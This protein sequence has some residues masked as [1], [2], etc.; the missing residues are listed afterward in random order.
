MLT[1]G[2]LLCV[3]HVGAEML[4]GQFD[5]LSAGGDQFRGCYELDALKAPFCISS[6]VAQAAFSA[7]AIAIDRAIVREYA[8]L[9]STASIFGSTEQKCLHH[10]RRARCA[11]AFRLSAVAKVCASTCTELVDAGCNLE[12]FGIEA[13]TAGGA[14]SDSGA[15]CADLAT[16]QLQCAFGDPVSHNVPAVPAARQSNPSAPRPVD[17]RSPSVFKP[18]ASSSAKMSVSFAYVAVALLAFV[19]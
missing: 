17:P 7:T 3:V 15:G 5:V 2:V 18:R 4:C 11:E 10:W 16:S 1:L 6:E 8:S 12:F 14:A 19:C 9:V 13:C